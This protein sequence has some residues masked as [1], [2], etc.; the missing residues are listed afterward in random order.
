MLNEAFFNNTYLQH[1][2]EIWYR[3]ALDGCLTALKIFSLRRS[4]L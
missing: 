3:V 1:N 2:L 4:I